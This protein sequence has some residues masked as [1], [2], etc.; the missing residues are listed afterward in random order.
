VSADVRDAALD[1]R[2]LVVPFGADRGDAAGP[3]LGPVSLAVAPGEGVALVGPS[4]A[5]KTTLLRAV[6]GLARPRAGAVHVG[7][8]DV[9]ALPPERRDAVYLHQTPVLFP[10]L[11]VLA[12]AR[13]PLDVRG[14]PRADRR[15][16]RARGARHAAPG[17]L[18]RRAAHALSGGQRHAWRS[19]RRG[20]R[21]ALL[22]LDEPL[23]ALD[24]R[25]ATRCATRSPPRA[26]RAAR[27]CSSSRTTST[28]P[29]RSPRASR[30]CSTGNSRRCRAG[31]ALRA[32][33]TLGVVRLLG[34][35]RELPG[36]VDADGAFRAPGLAGAFPAL[37][38]DERPVRAGPAV[39]A[40]R[41]DAVQLVR[42][43]GHAPA[44]Q[45]V[46]AAATAAARVVAVAPPRAWR[47]R[48]RGARRRARR[49]ARG[50]GRRA[51]PTGRGRGRARR[52]RRATRAVYPA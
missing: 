2:D 11:D 42:A 47:H 48:A 44:A 28:T 30:C 37:G 19:P 15:R 16:A 4:G 25:C 52:A 12:N 45:A 10:H 1:V 24:R 49:D 27:R 6:A 20:A 34:A 36:T 14:V 35:H 46:T 23:A 13:F 26:P 31:R 38:S 22:L 3:A 5:G 39:A 33:G 9:T 32:A 29:R 18:E 51:R 50:R 21:P 40:C 8:R 41:P 43:S 17:G 7:G